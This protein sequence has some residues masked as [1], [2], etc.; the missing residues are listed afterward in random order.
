MEIT[1][2]GLPQVGEVCL[3]E[4]ARIGAILIARRGGVEKS[5]SW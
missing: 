1:D 5:R 4:Q 2:G 3:L